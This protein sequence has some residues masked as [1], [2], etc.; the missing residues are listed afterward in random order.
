MRTTLCSSLS[1]YITSKLL[2]LLILAVLAMGIMATPASAQTCL[3]DEYNQVQKQ[4]LNCTANDVRVAKVINLRNLDG[5]SRFTCTGGETFAFTADF[6]VQTTSSQ[7]RSNIGLYF[8]TSD[9][10]NQP[11]ALTGSCADNI[12]APPHKASDTS[13]AACFGS[14]AFNDANCTG[15][16]TYEELDT[17][18]K[19]NP[20]EPSSCNSGVNCTDLPTGCGDTTSND[21]LICLTAPDTHGEQSV[22]GCTNA[23]KRSCTAANNCF[24]G[25]Q[26]VTVE[27]PSFTCPQAAA[28][29]EVTAGDCTSWQEPGGAIRCIANPQDYLY[30]FN[31]PPV[32]PSTMGTPTA[33]PGSPSKCNCEQITLPL[34]VQTPNFIVQKACTTPTGT[35]GPATFNPTATPPTQSPVTC[36]AGPEGNFQTVTYTI[37]IHNSSTG[38]GGVTVQQ[39][40]DSEFGTIYRNG[41]YTGSACSAGATFLGTGSISCPSSGSLDI[42]FGGNVQCTFT[43]TPSTENLGVGTNASLSDTA[44]AVAMGDVSHTTI[45]PFS[46][47]TVDVNT[48]DAPTSAETTP[49]PSALAQVCAR[50]T[51]HAT[52]ANTSGADETIFISALHDS[53][54]NDLTMAS[55]AG[56]IV[57]TTC[58]VSTGNGLGTLSSL[59]A[60]PFPSGGIAPSGNYQC[61]FDVFFCA[62]PTSVEAYGTGH[63][64]GNAMAPG[65]CTNSGG[66]TGSCTTNAQCDT[67][68]TGISRSETLNATLAGDDAASVQADTI[69]PITNHGGNVSV[70]VNTDTSIN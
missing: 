10:T 4:K 59:P 15:L 43:S 5:T 64:S 28:G 2:V 9:I 70:C 69:S 34:I 51:F 18:T 50:E 53:V 60:V 20:G 6:L 46:S 36:D 38:T 30:P 67:T 42:P 35:P 61:D 40:C 41:T 17:A 33:I 54:P 52:V 13:I 12:I 48:Q 68:C 62:V 26:V 44:S 57:G 22:V 1:R 47:N 23:Q 56:P 66:P 27:I 11:D 49:S 16:G 31:G 32:P 58:G 65:T 45:G 55:A 3:Q 14:G 21:G 29:T 24:A 19:S 25:T 39:L 8:A 7:A 37:N 63:C